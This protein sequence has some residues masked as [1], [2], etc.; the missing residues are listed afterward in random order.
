[1]GGLEARGFLLRFLEIV[2]ASQETTRD[3]PLTPK[4]VQSSLGRPNALL[5]STSARLNSR[6]RSSP[7]ALPGRQ[8]LAVRMSKHNAGTIA[9]LTL[10]LQRCVC[11]C[12]CP[13][14]ACLVRLLQADPQQT[15]SWPSNEPTGDNP[16]RYAASTGRV[17]RER[18]IAHQ[19]AEPRSGHGAPCVAAHGLARA[20]KQLSFQLRINY[21]HT[22]AVPDD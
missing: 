21:C 22:I 3:Q 17:R 18:Q 14:C 8:T 9:T 19:A 16:S 15:D 2:R 13:L 5:E 4:A 10:P 11:V 12:V 20:A 1:M 6:W 7:S